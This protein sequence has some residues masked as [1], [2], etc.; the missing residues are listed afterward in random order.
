M[1]IEIFFIENVKIISVIKFKKSIANTNI[2]DIIIGKLCIKKK[3]CLIILFKVNKDPKLGIYYIILFFNLA[4]YLWINGN[5]EFLFNI[6]K[7]A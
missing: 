5:E 6:K 2:F 4:V 3:L 1:E 7:I